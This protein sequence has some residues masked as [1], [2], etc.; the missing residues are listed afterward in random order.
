MVSYP[1][2]ASTMMHPNVPNVQMV[3]DLRSP[4]EVRV[5]PFR[6]GRVM[7]L[8]LPKP[9]LSA[10]QHQ[11]IFHHLLTYVPHGIR[12]GFVCSAGI[13]SKM[14]TNMMRG[15]GYNVIDLGGMN[16]PRTRDKLRKLGYWVDQW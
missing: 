4:E 7:G 12:V 13:L 14:A 3:I 1:A 11:Q 15:A 5:D 8:P 10:A 6:G 9:P 2:K 16:H